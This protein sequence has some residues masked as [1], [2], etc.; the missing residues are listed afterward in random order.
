MGA[1]MASP[2]FEGTQLTTSVRF[3]PLLRVERGAPM[4]SSTKGI[5]TLVTS[6]AVL[7]LLLVA[8]GSS[9]LAQDSAANSQ[10]PPLTSEQIRNAMLDHRQTVRDCVFGDQYDLPTQLN[11][12]VEFVIS[13]QGDVDSALMYE[14]NAG[15]DVVNTCVLDTV[16]G[17][18]FPDPTGGQ[19]FAV[20]YR[21]FFVTG[22]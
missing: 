5:A 8:L 6:T 18:E 1:Q 13:A 15:N 11:M 4:D 19:A 7:T 12:V 21:C 16:N 17:I 3:A 9:A 14:S 20:R 10:A 22:G 2:E